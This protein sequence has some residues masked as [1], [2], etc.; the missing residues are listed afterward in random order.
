MSYAFDANVNDLFRVTFKVDT[1][2]FE[3]NGRDA[4]IADMLEQVAAQVRESNYTGIVRDVNGNTI[5]DYGVKLADGH[6]MP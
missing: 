6:T 4:T 1:A 2:E 5:G 3:E